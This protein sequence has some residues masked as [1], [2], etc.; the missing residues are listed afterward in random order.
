MRQG[1]WILL[2]GLWLCGCTRPTQAV[3]AD[4]NPYGWEEEV[5]VKIEN[6][7]TLT[8]RDLS[9]VVRANRNFRLDTLHVEVTLKSPEAAQFSEVV[10]LPIRHLHRPAALR[11]ID[12]IPY[13]HDV[14]LNRFGTYWVTLRPLSPIRGIEAAGINVVK[15]AE[16]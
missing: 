9:L 6:A 10:A 14:V 5:R 8:L 3:M 13:R 2:C 11:L 12:E 7:D 1:V 15:A 16:D 4:V